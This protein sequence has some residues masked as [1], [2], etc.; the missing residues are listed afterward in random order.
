MN[1]TSIW[2]N[3]NREANIS[4]N[5]PVFRQMNAFWKG[6]GYIES[7]GFYNDAYGYDTWPVDIYY[8]YIYL[9]TGIIGSLIIAI[10]LLYILYRLIRKKDN[11]TRYVMLSVYIAILFDGLWQVNIF[12]YR[13]IATLFIGVLL[14]ITISLQD[15]RGLGEIRRN[16]KTK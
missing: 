16:E 11:F 12:T 6:M 13:Y 3:A 8:L 7:A 1:W 2:G 10:P 14:L 15:K 5:V 4:I 9:S